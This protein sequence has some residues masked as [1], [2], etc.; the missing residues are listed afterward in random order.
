MP[1]K[2]KSTKS[3]TSL[4]DISTKTKTLSSGDKKK[5]KGGLLPY[6]EQDNLN[7]SRGTKSITDGTSNITDGTSNTIKSK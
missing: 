3:R 7:T 4:K 5:I 1:S 2:S 6:I